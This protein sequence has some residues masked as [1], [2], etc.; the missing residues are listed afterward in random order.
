MKHAFAIAV[1]LDETLAATYRSIFELGQKKH[2]WDLSFEQ[3]VEYD[4]WNIPGLGI[5]RAQA[6]SLFDDYYTMN[7]TDATIPPVP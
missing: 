7:P 1:D 3:I 5:T 6:F 2:G 4:W